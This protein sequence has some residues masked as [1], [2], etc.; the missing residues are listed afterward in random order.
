MDDG[1]PVYEHPFLL[2]VDEPSV[3]YL[4]PWTRFHAQGTLRSRSITV[5]TRF[6]ICHIA[7]DI[8]TPRELSH[9]VA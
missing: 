1:R 9:P 2:L 3:R 5:Q 6:K 8:P 7:V 4:D